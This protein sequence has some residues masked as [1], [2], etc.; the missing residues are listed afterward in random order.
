MKQQVSL[1][2]PSLSGI[3]SFF[4]PIG[5][6]TLVLLAIAF[7]LGYG[8]DAVIREDLFIQANHLGGII[9]LTLMVVFGFLLAVVFLFDAFLCFREFAV[10]IKRWEKRGQP[11]HDAEGVVVGSHPEPTMVDALYVVGMAIRSGLVFLALAIIGD[12]A[13][14][15]VDAVKVMAQ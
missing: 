10:E 1:P 2:I 3:V 8:V 13:M 12:A 4:G 14:S 7:F 11:V 9:L 6:P 5:R 15:Y